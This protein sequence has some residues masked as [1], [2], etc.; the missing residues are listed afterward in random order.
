M[1]IPVSSSVSASH[2]SLSCRRFCADSVARTCFALPA[3]AK[4]PLSDKIDGVACH[5][6]LGPVVMVCVIWLL[7]Y[8]AIV[9]GY[10]ITHYTWPLLA[11]LLD[12]TEAVVPRSGFIEIPLIS[13][14]SLWVVDRVN[15]LLNYIPIF[16]MRV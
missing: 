15:A 3:G 6:W 10:H 5:K 2:I 1:K 11:W 12:L 13:A 16:F 8:L 9:Q 4:R 14:F 7:Y